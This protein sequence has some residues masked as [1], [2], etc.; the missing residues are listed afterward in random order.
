MSELKP[1]VVATDFSTCAEQAV[2]RAARLAAAGGNPLRLLHVLPP[3]RLAELHGK[4]LAARVRETSQQRLAA[5]VAALCKDYAIACTGALREDELLAAVSREVED[6]APSLL[7]LG[8]RGHSRLRRWLLGSTA[9]RLLEGLSLPMLVVRT[10]VTAAYGKL[11]VASDLGPAGMAAI[12]A[13]ATWA[14]DAHGLL[15]HVYRVPF[16]G[17][18]H[19]AGVTRA[20]I[21]GERDAA[22]DLAHKG[23]ARQLAAAAASFAGRLEG[24]LLEGDV[25]GQLLDIAREQNV[26]LLAVSRRN[27]AGV[28]NWALGSV[29]RHLLAEAH[30]DVLVVP[31]G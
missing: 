7:V 9:S 15:C 24:R 12:Q 8:A 5:A 17:V 25:A 29:A 22:Y 19:Y 31:P 28:P 1:I 4:A 20:L 13:A 6:S 2:Q 23:L 27:S 10:P 30:C 26:E 21:D 16:E 18:L 11:L 14:G 3:R